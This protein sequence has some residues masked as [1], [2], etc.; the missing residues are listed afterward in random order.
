MRLELAEAEL[1]RDEEAATAGTAGTA[2][3]QKWCLTNTS[4]CNKKNTRLNLIEPTL[5][6]TP[7]D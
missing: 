1:K 5:R 3:T 7:G 6:A 2:A 4:E